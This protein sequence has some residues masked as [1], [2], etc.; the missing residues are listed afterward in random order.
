M[1]GASFFAFWCRVSAKYG[2]GIQYLHIHSVVLPGCTTDIAF[3]VDTDLHLTWLLGVALI[4][5]LREVRKSPGLTGHKIGSWCIM[6]SLEV[7]FQLIDGLHTY[8]RAV[9]F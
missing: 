6:I 4:T 7:K 3:H 9:Q 8:F 2:L 1:L 5:E